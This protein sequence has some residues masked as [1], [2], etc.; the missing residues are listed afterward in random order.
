MREKIGSNILNAEEESVNTIM[1]TAWI[2]VTVAA[3]VVVV[4]FFDGSFKDG[5][6]LVV[7]A[8]GIAIRL[9][10]KKALW[11]K[12]YAKYAYMTLPIWCTA[13]LGIDN[14]G[15]FA[16]VTQSYFFY[17]VRTKWLEN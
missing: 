16:A 13:A 3:F 9:L 15:K 4:G 7:T 11:F 5:I 17:L 2:F 8:I 10:E 12:K 6:A 1:F 14:E